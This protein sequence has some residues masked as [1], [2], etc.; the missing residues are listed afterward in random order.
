MLNYQRSTVTTNKL[1]RPEK[2]GNK[3]YSSK[4]ID[5]IDNLA[6][7]LESFQNPCLTD[8]PIVKCMV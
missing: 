3:I 5:K 7:H 1:N 6:I 8:R 2:A 4:A